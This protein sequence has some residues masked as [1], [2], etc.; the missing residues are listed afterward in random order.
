MGSKN[1]SILLVS[2][3]CYV[4]TIIIGISIIFS[5][6]SKKKENLFHDAENSINNFMQADEALFLHKNTKDPF[7][8]PGKIPNRPSIL[9]TENATLPTGEALT[10]LNNLWLYLFD[11][12]TGYCDILFGDENYPWEIVLARR[13]TEREGMYHFSKIYPY[14]VGQYDDNQTSL[15]SLKEVLHEAYCSI[16]NGNTNHPDCRLN[17]SSFLNVIDTFNSAKNNYYNWGED[18]LS[19]WYYSNRVTASGHYC[20][21]TNT[22]ETLFYDVY[23]NDKYAVYIGETQPFLTARLYF[24]KD[25]YKKDISICL[26]IFILLI[27]ICCPIIIH[28][29][30]RYRQ[31]EDQYKSIKKDYEYGLTLWIEQNKL[32]NGNS[33]K[34]AIAAINE[35]KELDRRIRIHNAHSNLIKRQEYISEL[36]YEKIKNTTYSYIRTRNNEID[37]FD[38]Q[39]N[40]TKI[41]YPITICSYYDISKFITEADKFS[42]LRLNRYLQEQKVLI[43][44]DVLI[45]NKFYYAEREENH[46]DKIIKAVPGSY[47]I[48]LGNSGLAG[49]QLL[50]FKEFDKFLED[51][52]TDRFDT[53]SEDFRTIYQ[54]YEFIYAK[55]NYFIDP[56][57]GLDRKL[58]S[59]SHIYT[60]NSLPSELEITDN[61]II[62]DRFADIETIQNTSNVIIDHYPGKEIN[63][64]YYAFYY[65]LSSE[66]TQTRINE[67]NVKGAAAELEIA[68]YIEACQEG[69]L[70]KIQE[71][72]RR[73]SNLSY[74]YGIELD[75][76]KEV[77]NAF[78]IV[79]GKVE[80]AISEINI[81]E[82]NAIQSSI[83][84]ITLRFNKWEKTK[85]EINKKV[86]AFLEQ[87]SAGIP[88]KEHELLV[89][90]DYQSIAAPDS[91]PFYYSP[92]M[93]TPILPFRRHRTLLEGASEREFYLKIKEY[94]DGDILSVYNDVSLQAFAGRYPMEPDIAI[95]SKSCKNLRIDIEIDEPYSGY[96]RNPIHFIGC[97]EERDQNLIN[98]GWMVIRISEEQVVSFPSKCI[99]YI[100]NIIADIIPSFHIPESL[101]EDV[102]EPEKSFSI[103]RWTKNEAITMAKENYRETYLNRT[104]FGYNENSNIPTE[105]NEQTEEEARISSNAELVTTSKSG[106]KLSKE[107]VT[108]SDEKGTLIKPTSDEIR[109]M[110]LVRNRTQIEITLPEE[111]KDRT[112]IISPND[113][114][115]E[116]YIRPYFPSM[117]QNAY[118]RY[119]AE[120][121]FLEHQIL[122][123]YGN[124]NR[125]FTESPAFKLI[126]DY[127]NSNNLIPTYAG[128]QIRHPYYNITDRIGFICGDTLYDAK[129]YRPVGFLCKENN[130]GIG[131][132]GSSPDFPRTRYSIE[133]TIKEIIVEQVLKIKIR[134]RIVLEV[135]LLTNTISAFNLPRNKVAKFILN[136]EYDTTVKTID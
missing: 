49:D 59:E 58:L 61:V 109:V 97:D 82:I 12:I 69:N 107:N 52:A 133:E 86:S 66:E 54:F 104:G 98:L 110:N 126:N 73:I 100:C 21:N 125:K 56:K 63:I 101:N 114:T 96:D 6:F 36:F 22:N 20:D 44:G 53:I 136:N 25:S 65:S 118:I 62:I 24:D 74:A 135:N 60:I 95:I 50:N 41:L 108:K 42:Q 105:E 45:D 117:S 129:I 64:L 120:Q 4:V 70:S 132:A 75:I 102:I 3:V 103:Q 19:S 48:I 90:Y 67:D 2:F 34:K 33:H 128:K 38:S 55:T 88:V 43:C 119:N 14:A 40:P 51:N 123:Y 57:E 28:F 99:L 122:L 130:Y 9:D 84:D 23:Q 112:E 113:K 16:E 115:V 47:T 30:Q 92:V 131:V 46:F 7:F 89:D 91:Y 83:K 8:L 81:K 85:E 116:E 93:G 1:K 15:T 127:I 78:L 71:D 27:T 76:D 32:D 124:N 94:L 31:I 5:S 35:I 26:L 79:L 13:D 106:T 111:R 18:I 134:R 10:Y 68:K 37:S 29:I 87:Y 72:L 121:G 17:K 11:D 80:K 77:N 39:A